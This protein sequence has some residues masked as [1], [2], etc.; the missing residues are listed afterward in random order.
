MNYDENH[1]YVLF[2]NKESGNS[3]NK[4][5]MV[6]ITG[7]G[8]S[9][10]ESPWSHSIVFG[11]QNAMAKFNWLGTHY[12]LA[13]QFCHK[14]VEYWKETLSNTTLSWLKFFALN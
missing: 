13:S 2:F 9:M 8:L 5:C 3:V 1:L 10:K 7:A 12:M 14:K 4:V 6:L 11:S